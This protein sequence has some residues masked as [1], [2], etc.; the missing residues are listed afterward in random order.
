MTVKDNIEKFLN[1]KNI[2]VAGV[3][4]SGK[5]FGNTILDSLKKKNYHTFII[6]PTAE[7]LNKDQC[8]KSFSDLPIAPD[9]AIVI[10][11]PKDAVVSVIDAIDAGVK[12]IWIQLGSSS[13]EV[14][15]LCCNANI[16]IINNKCLLMYL[17]EQGFPHNFH[18]F[19]AKL[20]GTLYK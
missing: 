1:S 18:R 16:D 14:V 6:H 4:R 20:F 9:A 11:H 5:K 3:S 8:W 19:M 7:S 12:L 13:P 15:E 2:A 10:L 17:G